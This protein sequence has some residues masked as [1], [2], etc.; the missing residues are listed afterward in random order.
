MKL[1]KDLKT[2]LLHCANKHSP[3]ENVLDRYT[4]NLVHGTKENIPRKTPLL[5]DIPI[6]NGQD[7]SQLEDW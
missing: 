2:Y 3:V 5:Q 7:P 1:N 4:E 6:L